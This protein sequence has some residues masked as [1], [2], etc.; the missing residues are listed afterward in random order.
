[1]SDHQ[2][3]GHNHNEKVANK[4]G[5]DSYKAKFHLRKIKS[6]LNSGKA[7]Y[8]GVQT[9]SSFWLDYQNTVHDRLFQTR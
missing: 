5:N 3:A 1:M 8:Y 4:Y 2:S 6:R 7:C 9:V